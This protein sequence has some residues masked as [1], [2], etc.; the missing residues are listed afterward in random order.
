MNELMLLDAHKKNPCQ[1]ELFGFEH[2]ACELTDHLQQQF[3]F[4]RFADS[5]KL[6]VLAEFIEEIFEH[7]AKIFAIHYFL[8]QCFKKRQIHFSAFHD[9]GSK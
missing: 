8:T 4:H 9:R 2:L 5:E 6:R 3:I 7:F 1:Q